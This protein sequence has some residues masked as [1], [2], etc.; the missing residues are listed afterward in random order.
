MLVSC[1]PQYDLNVYGDV[2][3]GGTTA[4]TTA[5]TSAMDNV[6]VEG[7]VAAYQVIFTDSSTAATQF[8]NLN[9]SSTPTT[10]T[11]ETIA[12]VFNK[13]VVSSSGAD[14]S[15]NLMTIATGIG[16]NNELDTTVTSTSIIH[17]Y[18]PAS[19]LAAC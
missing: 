19:F 14:E 12:V 11:D 4:T 2:N 5:I 16:S 15:Y 1:P 3:V 9:T 13:Y 17:A 8:I 6:F 10:T 7:S 18:N